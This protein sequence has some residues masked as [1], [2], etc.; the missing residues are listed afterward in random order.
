[1]KTSPASIRDSWACQ[2]WG[3]KG[4]R[5]HLNVTFAAL[6]VQALLLLAGFT[7]FNFVDPLVPLSLFTM[8]CCLFLLAGLK[9]IGMRRKSLLQVNEAES[10]QRTG[11]SATV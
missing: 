5:T 4:A 8:A 1:M 7:Y 9:L 3:A 10:G 6:A 11:S 2:K